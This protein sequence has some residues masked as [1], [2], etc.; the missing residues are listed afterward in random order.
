MVQMVILMI[1]V[2]FLSLTL[3]TT[4]EISNGLTYYKYA[5]VLPYLLFSFL[6][7]RKYGDKYNQYKKYW[8][9]EPNYPKTFL[10]GLGKD[11]EYQSSSHQSLVTS[12]P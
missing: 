4:E 3:C 6:A 5:L 10:P 12:H 9:D 1:V 11:A 8:K 7:F 2:A